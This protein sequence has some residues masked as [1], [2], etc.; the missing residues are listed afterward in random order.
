MRRLRCLPFVLLGAFSQAQDPAQEADALLLPLVE[1]HLASDTAADVAWGGQL[2]WQHR[3]QAARRPLLEAM[4]KWKGRDGIEARFVRLHL[5]D[6]M[7]GA[8]V[9][10]PGERVEFLLD[11]PLT[12]PGAL[13]LIADD[14]RAN[15][16][17]LLKIAMTP[18]AQFD[19]VRLT[20]ARLVAAHELK[21]ATFT[22]HLLDGLQA[23]FVAHITDAGP[24]ESQWN[25]AVGLGGG[26]RPTVRLPAGFPAAVRHTISGDDA[27]GRSNGTTT[28]RLLID[29]DGAGPTTTL[30]RTTKARYWPENLEPGERVDRLPDHQRWALLQV[31]ATVTIPDST[32]V[33]HS[34]QDAARYRTE[35]TA[36]RDAQRER[37]DEALKKLRRGGW[38]GRK[39][40]V[41]YRIPLDV[42]IHDERS[43]KSTALPDLPPLP[44]PR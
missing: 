18:A 5:L 27:S 33:E 28:E 8:A 26:N 34:F 30:L 25:S 14:W 38:L 19:A 40:L 9:K 11:D 3:L 44:D 7:L 4:E 24:P 2:V 42:Q 1:Q 20:A 37:L 32:F 15:A 22:T 10:V 31:M 39:D 12:R 23:E 41:G 29:A 36:A 17:S 43:D 21:S 6:G 35:L 13:A 16:A